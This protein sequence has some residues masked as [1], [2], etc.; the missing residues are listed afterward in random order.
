MATAFIAVASTN[1]LAQRRPIDCSVSVVSG[2][3]HCSLDSTVIVTI[4]CGPL[5][6]SDSLLLYDITLKYPVSKLSFRQVLYQN[7]L[8]ENLDSRGYRILDSS[9]I[10]V[11]GFNVTRFLSGSKP[12]VALV[13]KH[14]ANCTDSI[15]FE[16]AFLPEFNPE[17]KVYIREM[18]SAVVPIAT[19]YDKNRSLTFQFSNDTIVLPSNR[20]SFIA[21]LKFQLNGTNRTRAISLSFEISPLL[22]F[23]SIKASDYLDFERFDSG[24][25]PTIRITAV[26]NRILPMVD[27]LV[28]C[29][30][31]YGTSSTDAEF[32]RIRKISW[33]TCSC[34]SLGVGDS[35]QVKKE[36]ISHVSDDGYTVNITSD[37]DVWDIENRTDAPALVDVVNMHGQVVWNVDLGP[38]ERNRTLSTLMPSG[39]YLARITTTNSRFYTKLKVWK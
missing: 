29:F 34:L 18:R 11:Y 16:F 30:S 15:P 4:D 9:A 24:N 6:S 35:L 32:V 21:P 19:A 7:T 28:L 26:A 10:R 31:H 27:S 36:T 2:I 37:G 22:V 23:D 39:V 12:L 20:T 1:T 14:K 8:S 13:F 33:D 38:G 17:S 5:L 25:S 3:D